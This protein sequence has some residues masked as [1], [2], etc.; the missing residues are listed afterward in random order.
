MESNNTI[1]GD[2]LNHFYFEYLDSFHFVLCA[3]FFWVVR[4]KQAAAAYF[5]VLVLIFAN[6]FSFHVINT[7]CVPSSSFSF[8]VPIKSDTISRPHLIV[9]NVHVFFFGS[10][11]SMF[12]LHFST[13]V[14]TLSLSLFS[15]LLSILYAHIKQAKK[16]CW[17]KGSYFVF[18][19]VSLYRGWAGVC[20]WCL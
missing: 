12:P 20:V 11:F 8:L 17:K 19:G 15:R 4:H 10:Y 18:K 13:F 1:G 2:L 3:L 9:I 14:S 7:F 6:V 16:H 5:V